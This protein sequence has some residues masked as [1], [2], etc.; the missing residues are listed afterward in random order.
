MS[1]RI[2]SLVP[3]VLLA[4][5]WPTPALAC[6]CGGTI[7]TLTAAERAGVVFVGTVSRIDS[8]PPSNARYNADGSVGVNSSAAGPDFVLF[9]VV[10]VF[11]GPLVPEVGVLRGNSTCDFPF[12]TGEEWLVYGD[13]AIGG[14]T[15]YKCS[16]TRL[17]VSATQ[18]LVYLRGVDAR[19]PQGILYGEVL[20][21]GDGP[22]GVTRSALFEPLQVIAAN[23]TQKF[24]TTTEPWG[25]FELVVPPGDFDVWVERREKIVAP[26]R[27]VHVN[28][29]AEVKVQLLVAYSTADR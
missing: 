29:G 18:D 28:N 26:K 3:V 25:A 27:V 1:A 23:M 10:R 6:G 21:R 15:A 13:E 7:S 14:I 22:D 11:K 8:P 16:R 4:I 5:F 19:R 2:A 17:T 12:R 9:D 20:R 24:T